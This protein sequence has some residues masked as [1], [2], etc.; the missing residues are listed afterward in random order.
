MLMG[1]AAGTGA[2]RWDGLP[3]IDAA[4]KPLV[5]AQPQ[6][7]SNLGHPA[8]TVVSNARP[9]CVTWRLRQKGLLLLRNDRLQA[10]WATHRTLSSHVSDHGE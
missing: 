8:V 5:A 1:R 10:T 7:V 9:P 3:R 4:E 2:C 6:V